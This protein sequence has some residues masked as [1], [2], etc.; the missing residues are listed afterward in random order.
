M[1]LRSAPAEQSRAEKFT[2]TRGNREGGSPDEAQNHS[3]KVEIIMEPELEGAIDNLG[4]R[5]VEEGIT[6][7]GGTRKIA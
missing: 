4:Q 7:R 1:D 6:E 2:A 5:D 3:A